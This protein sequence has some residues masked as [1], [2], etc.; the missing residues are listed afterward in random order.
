MSVAIQG[1]NKSFGSNRVLSDVN[2]SIERG[3]LFSIVGPSGSG[4]TTLLRIVAGLETQDSG[5]VSID[6]K[7][8]DSVPPN[9]RNVGMVFQNYALYPNKTV[10]ENI[11]SPLLVKGVRR[12]Q[13]FAEVEELAKRLGIEEVLDRLPGQISGG[14][15]QRVALARALIK[16]PDVFLLDEPLS[17]LDAQLRF[18][19]RK[20]VRQL[21]R[22]L[23]IT[24]IYVTHDQ[25]EALSISD[26][27]AVMSRGRVM[28]VGSPRELYEA[29]QN[30]FVASFIGSPPLNLMDARGGLPFKLPVSFNGSCSKVGIRPEAIR[31]GEGEDSAEVTLVEYSGS[32]AVVYIRVG[33]L[34]LRALS[35]GKQSH[36]VGETIRFQVQE[37]GVYLFDEQGQLLQPRK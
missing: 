16:K 29:P 10:A 30:E 3:E 18:N 37:G 11:A 17:N 34:E 31:L 27:I 23:G 26:R 19:A 13:A 12:E 24:T 4:K 15:Q 5:H 7:V 9:R 14:Q 25:S 28:Q 22:D 8:V 6:G 36:R 35:F 1:L 2:I 32:E 21:Q 20:F 33:G